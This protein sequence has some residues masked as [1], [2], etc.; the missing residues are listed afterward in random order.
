MHKLDS[1]STCTGKTRNKHNDTDYDVWVEPIH[2]HKNR[3]SL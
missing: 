1:A 3:P 2:R